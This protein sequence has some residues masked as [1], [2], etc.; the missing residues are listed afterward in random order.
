MVTS[1]SAWSWARSATTRTVAWPA[2]LFLLEQIGRRHALVV[3]GEVER[4]GLAGARLQ[5][6]LGGAQD[7]EGQRQARRRRARGVGHLGGDLVLS[8]SLAVM[9]VGAAVSL[10]V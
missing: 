5:D 2:H 3:G 6:G 4:R 1:T 9:L 7:R 10:M 8:V